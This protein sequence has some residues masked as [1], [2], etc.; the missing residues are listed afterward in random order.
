MSYLKFDKNQLINLEYS[1]SRELLRTNRAGSY[2]FTTIVGCNTRKYHGLFV[3]P[4]PLVDQDNHVLLSSID[5]T[6]IQHDA[7]FNLAIH[8]FKGDVLYSQRA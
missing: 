5:E 4:Q 1:L 2:G 3:A 7:E 8:K 6:I